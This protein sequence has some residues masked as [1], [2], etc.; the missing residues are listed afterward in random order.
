MEKMEIINQGGEIVSSFSLNPKIWQVSLS[1]PLISLAYRGYFTNQHQN[2]H[3]TKSKGEVNK[4]TKKS[5]RQKHTGM[6][7]QGPR[8]NP[9]FV[10]GGV[11]HGPRGEKS[12]PL[13]V[14]KKVKKKALQSLLSE[15]IRRKEIIIIEKIVLENYKTK[16]AEKLLSGLPV[17]KISSLIVLGKEEENK[18]KLF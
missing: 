7:R 16:E 13:R 12:L 8:S 5:R 3:K 6:A 11:A 10:G 4:T 14:N 15:K 9:H 1:R 2:T 17:G 18:E